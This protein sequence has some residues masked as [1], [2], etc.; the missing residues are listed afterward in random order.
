[1]RPPLR[2]VVR[3]PLTRR[4]LM[5]A[6]PLGVVAAG[7]GA[8]L[9]RGTQAEAS[10]TTGT[11]RL[12][13]MHC[14]LSCT[15]RDGRLV[16]VEGDLKARTKGFVCEHG[17]ALR[18]LVHSG[19]RLKAPLLRRGEAFHEVSWD[20]ALAEVAQKLDAVKQRYGP[21]AFLIQ[22]GWPLVRHPLVDVLHRFARAFGSPN[23]ASVASLC[24]ASL[25]MGQ[26]LTVGSK[27]APDVQRAKTFVVWG[28][29]PATT[30]PPFAHV[31][32][33][34]ALKGALVVVD[35]VKTQ[36]ARDAT[37]YVQVRPGTDGAL[38]LGLLHVIFKEGW[39]DRAALERDSVGLA[40]L[41]A[42]AATF[43][44]ERVAQ[45]TSVPSEQL[46]RVAKRLG[47]EGPVGIW[48][49]L[50]VEHHE[51]GVQTVRAITS[52]EVVCGRFPDGLVGRAVLTPPGAHLAREPLP[53]LYRMKTP[54][55]VPPPVTVPPLGRAT[56]PLFELFNREAQGQDL[57][58][59]VLEDTPYPVRAVML[60]ASNA[61]VTSAQ[62]QRLS[63]AVDKLELLV[64]VDPF[65]TASARRA[66]VVLPAA[67]FAEAPD[68]DEADRVAAQGL[69]PVQHDARD[70]YRIIAGLAKAMGLGAYFPWPTFAEYRAAP[71]LPWMDED[72]AL[73]PVPRPVDA[74]PRFSTLSG[75]VEFSS[76]LLTSVGASA[77]PDWKPPSAA[78]SAEFP[79]WLVTGPR[80]RAYINSQ[81]H[82]VPSI[83]A[84]MRQ[85]E[86]LVHEA[87]ARTAGVKDGAKVLVVSPFGGVEARAVVTADVHPETV[88]IPAGWAEAN[89][90]VLIGPSVEDA[91]SGFPAF[92]SG[93]CR[94]EPV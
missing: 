60:V 24:E 70:D 49:G 35:P 19:A 54:A 52:L 4:E 38:A 36:L 17:F 8:L 20:D 87:V 94:V 39:R 26:A 89:V 57:P 27:Y 90:N 28:A 33:Q 85:C 64:S 72:A 9:L 88:V 74:Q 10:V 46:L 86:V 73:R 91:I 78:P 30:A 51:H 11:C 40:E 29:N 80:P 37:E 92:R 67:T 41:E 15:V 76:S 56:H 45:L 25:R 61:L 66:D 32:A 18:E 34:K 58:A 62:T 68:V 3:R 2:H 63:A 71:Q 7:A 6:A 48:Q 77:V 43:P 31:V 21:Q 69:V 93:T 44:P 12:C 83:E 23:V 42:L 82:G 81:F 84:R 50:G 16:K 53:A 14:G 1:M 59:A 5:K 79:L 13:L 75:R 65:F 22:T 55:P 47:T